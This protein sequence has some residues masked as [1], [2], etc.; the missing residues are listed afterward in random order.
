MQSRDRQLSHTRQELETS[1]TEASSLQGR[2]QALTAECDALRARVA[3]LEEEATRRE[4]ALDAARQREDALKS[5]LQDLHAVKDKLAEAQALCS[6]QQAVR[7]P[8]FFCLPACLSISLS[9]AKLPGRPVCASM[10]PAVPRTFCHVH[11]FSFFFS[12]L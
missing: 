3:S 5:D 11:Q 6:Q 8:A 7:Q 10:G 9:V 1:R 4:T 2:V 12:G